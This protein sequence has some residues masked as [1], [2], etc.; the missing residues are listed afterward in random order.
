MC[1][2]Y[3]PGMIHPKSLLMFSTYALKIFVKVLLDFLMATI[4]YVTLI[5]AP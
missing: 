2:F 3:K 5:S 4:A 1:E